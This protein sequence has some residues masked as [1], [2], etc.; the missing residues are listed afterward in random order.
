M[1]LTYLVVLPV[2]SICACSMDSEP[3]PD[4]YVVDVG[5]VDHYGESQEVLRAPATVSAGDEV[6][7]VVA[8]YG[9]GCTESRDLD[10]DQTAALVV[11][12]PYDATYVPPPS[13]PPAACPDLLQRL[14]HRV[15]VS[16]A[17]AGTKTVRVVGRR[18]GPA[19]DE[20]TALEWTI[21]VD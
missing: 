2:V 1:R 21:E 7:L 20:L 3:T 11:L 12:T 15:R 14:E 5:V 17:S 16:F 13:D 18:I 9:G 8:T 19:E 4:P 6:E 10:V